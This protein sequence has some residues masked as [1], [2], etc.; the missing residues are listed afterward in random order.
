MDAPATLYCVIK[1]GSSWAALVGSDLRADRALDGGGLGDAT[2][3]VWPRR[4]CSPQMGFCL[5]TDRQTAQEP[6]TLCPL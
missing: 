3:P 1:A 5:P 2:L 6:P 4:E